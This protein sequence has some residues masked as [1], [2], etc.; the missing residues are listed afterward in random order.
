MCGVLRCG[1]LNEIGDQPE[2]IGVLAN[3]AERVIAVGMTRLNEVEHLD[4]ISLL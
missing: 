2:H 4:N 3:I 1:V